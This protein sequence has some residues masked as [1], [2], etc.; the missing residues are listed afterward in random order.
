MIASEQANTGPELLVDDHRFLL[1]GTGATPDCVT[2]A[3]QIRGSARRPYVSVL[4]GPSGRNVLECS[5]ADHA[6]HLGLWW[7]H[8]DVNGV[9]FYLELEREDADHGR[10][11][12]V[13]FDEIV[14]DD[15]WFGFDEAL[16][17]RDPDGLVLLT[18]RRILLAHF[19][20]DHWYTLDLDST[21]TAVADVV[22][23]DT[24]ESV[25]PGVRVAE[26]LTTNGGGTMTSSTGG[27]GEPECFGKAADWVDRCG[28]RRGIWHKE[29]VEGLA[30]FDHPGNP[31]PA[32][33]FARDYGPLSPFPG[34]H[35][36]GGGALAEG[37]SLRLRHRVLVHEGDTLDARVA[38]H[39]ARY[40][41]EAAESGAVD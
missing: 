19:A 18:E 1:R 20:D 2:L 25:L 10:I 12:H 29:V 38:E 11:E 9:D 24:K 6:H 31:H 7:G 16:E 21:Y 8:G 27:V 14:D 22:F 17:W 4:V 33:W 28:R 39:Y 41:E 32:T 13:S 26:V 30:V 23:G 34:H 37:E 5:P 40:V 3:Y 15:P 36:L 35:F